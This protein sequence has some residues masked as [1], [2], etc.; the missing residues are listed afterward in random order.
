MSEQA[1]KPQASMNDG[2]DRKPVPAPKK[3]RRRS[4]EDDAHRMKLGLPNDMETDGFQYRWAKGTG[5]RISQLEARGY[6]RVD[7][8]TSMADEYSGV[9]RRI[10]EDRNGDVET[11]VL[12]RIPKKYWDEDL[13]AKRR[14]AQA[15][16]DELNK[17][18]GRTR[19]EVQ[20]E[21][22]RSKLS[23]SEQ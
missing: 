1:T 16:M 21:E 5:A 17:L 15:P 20:G 14:Q 2:K 23:I 9:Q 13:E 6:E 4:Y 7:G 18:E 11:G 3:R 10:G 8:D 19:A 12:M 22:F